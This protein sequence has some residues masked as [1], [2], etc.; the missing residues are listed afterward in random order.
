MLEPY[1]RPCRGVTFKVYQVGI[2]VGSAQAN[3]SEGAPGW[4]DGLLIGLVIY[5]A[6]CAVWMLT[7]FGGER[8]THYVGLLADSPA[9]LTAVSY[10]HL[11][12]YKR[13]RSPMQRRRS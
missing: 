6:I 8:I 11:D 13:Q 10:T 2:T 4:V 9:C 12:V 5:V 7:G 3:R 1:L